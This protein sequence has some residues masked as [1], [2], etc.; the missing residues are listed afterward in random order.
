MREH[1]QQLEDVYSSASIVLF[2]A[3][4]STHRK[5][6]FAIHLLKKGCFL[7]NNFYNVIWTMSRFYFLNDQVGM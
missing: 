3:G 5:T 1:N 4:L 2:N 6:L 7:G